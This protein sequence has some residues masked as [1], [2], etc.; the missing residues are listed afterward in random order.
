MYFVN[1]FVTLL[2]PSHQRY[3]VCINKVVHKQFEEELK[4]TDA[5]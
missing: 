3:Y 1:P 2:C 5:F 4:L